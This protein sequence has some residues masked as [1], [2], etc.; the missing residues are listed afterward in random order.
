M[1]QV[2]AWLSTAVLSPGGVDAGALRLQLGRVNSVV[3]VLRALAAPQA[4]PP[5]A[6]P[7]GAAAS[8]A[9]HGDDLEAALRLQQCL[10]VRRMHVTLL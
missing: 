6:A 10:Q 1:K 7:L 4:A 8:E 9:S 5:V 3:L 2:H